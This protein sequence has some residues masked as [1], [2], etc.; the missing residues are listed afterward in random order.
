M[1]NLYLT[2]I[3]GCGKTSVGKIAAE[4]LGVHFFDVDK[5]IEKDQDLFISEIFAQYNE[6][7]FR[8]V[9]SKVLQKLSN[10]KN[11]IISTGGG[12][13]LKKDNIDIMKQTGSIVWIKRPIEMIS[14]CVDASFRPLIADDPQRLV[15]IY[16]E[17]EPLYKSCADYIVGNE[18]PVEEAAQSVVEIFNK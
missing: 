18:G 12:I 10:L 9:E 15:K 4:I 3:M 11:A 16:Q 17:R 2:G 1:N 8:D 7:Y 14:E 6:T 13:I 5:E